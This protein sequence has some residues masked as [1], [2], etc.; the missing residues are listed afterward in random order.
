MPEGKLKTLSLIK[1]RKKYCSREPISGIP[2]E[3]E[4]ELP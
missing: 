1:E 3:A 2:I 4:N